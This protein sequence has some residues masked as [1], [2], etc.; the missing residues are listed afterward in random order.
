MHGYGKMNGRQEGLPC[1]EI[2]RIRGTQELS[3]TLV[4]FERQ[5]S[6]LVGNNY[7]PIHKKN[8]IFL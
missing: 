5:F 2:S 4:N 3:V 6:P 1:L 7:I 8:Y